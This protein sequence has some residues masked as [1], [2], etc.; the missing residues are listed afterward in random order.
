MRL[1]HQRR[2]AI[3]MTAM[4]V[5]STVTWLPLGIAPL[6]LMMSRTGD[7]GT[8][9]RWLLLVA[10]M[11]LSS[12]VS[13]PLMHVAGGKNLRRRAVAFF[14]CHRQKVGTSELSGKVSCQNRDRLHR[15]VKSL[16]ATELEL[17][18]R[19]GFGLELCLCFWLWLGLVLVFVG[20]DFDREP[21]DSFSVG[22]LGGL[23]LFIG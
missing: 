11:A 7:G 20:L 2:L 23:T 8:E 22:G 13:A 17:E 9:G 21:S 16:Q 18:L 19:P 3:A 10:I 4:V 1:R 15:A 5:V 14:F 12:V 6:A